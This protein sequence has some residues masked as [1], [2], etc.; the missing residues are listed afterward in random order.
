[1][2]P[3]LTW[4]P[5][6]H[7]LSRQRTPDHVNRKIDRE[8]NAAIELAGESP[9]LIRARLDHIDREWHL[10]RALIAVFSVLGSATASLAMRS[11]RRKGRIGGFGVLFFTQMAFLLNH[12]VRGWCPPVAVLRRLGVR[13]AREICAER[14]AL[15]KKL[16]LEDGP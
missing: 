3:T 1:M 16:A 14:C 6:S 15:E 8:I 2:N 4:Q 13:T 5:P 9:L 10:D 12:A 7:D 11:L